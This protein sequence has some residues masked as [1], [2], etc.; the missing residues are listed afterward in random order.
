MQKNPG[1]LRGGRDVT[2]R[3][4]SFF[5]SFIKVTFLLPRASREALGDSWGRSWEAM[6]VVVEGVERLLGGP[7]SMPNPMQSMQISK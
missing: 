4:K 7:S 6:L 3:S 2:I 1:R 5:R